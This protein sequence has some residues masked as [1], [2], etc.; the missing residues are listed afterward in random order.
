MDLQRLYSVA[1]KNVLITGGVNGIGRMLS[2]GF[3]AA[4]ARVF[5]TGRKA[6]A[7]ADAISALRAAGG[8]VEGLVADL[9]TSAG[10]AAVTEWMKASVSHLDV[11]LNN[12]GQTWGAPFGEFPSKAW[13]PVLHVNV[14]TPFELAQG[15]LPLLETAACDE[16]PARIINVGS[17]Y[18]ETTEVLTAYS[19]TA[20][21][22]AIHQLTRVMARELAPKRIL[23]NAVAPGLFPSKMT[24]FL[25]SDAYQGPVVAGIPL[26][27][28][29]TPEDIVGLTIF[30]SSRASAYITGAVIPI[31]GGILIAH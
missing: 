24:R 4:G 13:E 8:Q 17:V 20:S 16:N 14:Q 2:E 31:D 25:L 23:C 27:R 11:L 3:A 18:A 6:D 15:L 19:Y 28:A 10:V 9:S 29:G 30:L 7:L 12:A 26:A 21:K 1:G 22:A 5:I